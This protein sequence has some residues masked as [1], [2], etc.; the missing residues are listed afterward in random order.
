LDSRV[1]TKDV[2]TAAPQGLFLEK[3]YY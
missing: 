1:R 2:V 3:V